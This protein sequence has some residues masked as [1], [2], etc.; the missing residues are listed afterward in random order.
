MRTS[1]VELLLAAQTE[2]GECPVWDDARGALFFMDILG[3]KLHCLDWTTRADT[4]FDLPAL[5]GGLAAA[6]DGRLIAGL[7][8]G[9]HMVDPDR[10]T[11]EFLLDPEPGKPDHRLNEAKCDPQGR[12]WVGSMSTLGRFP[13]GC[14]Y[15]LENNGSVAKVLTEI[16]VP[17]TMAWLPGG[18][19]MLFADSVRKEVWK[20]RYDPESGNL[21]GRQLYLDVGDYAGIPDG[22]AI[23]A[24][25]YAWIA[26]FGG[27]AV[28]RY[29]PSG[30]LVREVRLPATQVTSC[31]FVGARLDQLAI[32]TSKRL[33][34]EEQ[35]QAQSHAGDLFL[36][37]V[38]TPGLEPH[39]F[40]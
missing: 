22:V 15:K 8:T 1:T 31:A 27:G 5:G 4:V 21:S 12:F 32:I 9:I 33:L 37:E 36:I 28:R 2:L 13:T 19:E 24:E 20:F 25:G 35:R 23:D 10:G 11:F 3:K 14:L 29:S 7:Q 26:E 17:N 18:H 6:K 39:K 40:G 38:E 34:N 16:S 30:K